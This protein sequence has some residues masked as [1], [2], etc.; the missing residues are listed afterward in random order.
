M[1]TGPKRAARTPVRAAKAAADATTPRTRGA[2]RASYADASDSDDDALVASDQRQ[3]RAGRDQQPKRR[4]AAADVVMVHASDTS[5]SDD[6]Q[7]PPA[8]R[9]Q[10]QQPA[11]SARPAVVSDSEAAGD[12]SDSEQQHTAM[13]GGGSEDEDSFAT[14][15]A[16]DSA[17]GGGAG[18]GPDSESGSESGDDVRPFHS[19]RASS[20]PRGKAPTAAAAPARTPRRQGAVA[21]PAVT[22]RRGAGGAAP[23]AA[24]TPRSARGAA[25]TPSGRLARSCT[26]PK[27]AQPPPSLATPLAKMSLATPPAARAPASAKLRAR[28]G[29]AAAAAVPRAGRRAGGVGGGAELPVGAALA[30]VDVDGEVIGPGDD[31][32][33]RL[34][35][36]EYEEDED[37]A[38]EVCH[39]S[40]CRRGNEILECSTCLRGFHLRCL[41]PPLKAVPDGD[42]LCPEC[43]AGQVPPPPARL[44]AK[45][46]KLLHGTN[47]LALVHVLGCQRGRAPDGQ[48]EDQLLVRYYL[49]PQE[50]HLGRTRQHGAREVFLGTKMYVEP[51]AALAGRAFVHAPAAFADAREEEGNDVFV[52]DYEYDETWRRFKR[53]NDSDSD[54]DGEPSGSGS[55]GES[56]DGAYRPELAPHLRGA[57]GGAKRKRHGQ[58]PAAM[59]AAAAAAER[60]AGLGAGDLGGARSEQADAFGRLHAALSLAAVPASLP[61]RDDERVRLQGFVARALKEDGG[62]L[63]ICGVPGTGKTALVMEVLN[64]QAGDAVAAGSQLV[65]INCLQLPSPQHVFSRLWE[66]LSGQHL[67][68]ARARD[69][70]QQHFGVG[71]G[72][73]GGPRRR[74]ST[75]IV[76][77]EIDMLLTRDQAVLYQLFDWPATPGSRL[78][79]IGIS[80]THDLDARVLPRIASR[81]DQAKLPFAPYGVQ[82]LLAIVRARLHASAAAG[83]VEEAAV[84]LACRKV[85]SETGDVRRA[86]ELLRRAVEIARQQHLLEHSVTQSGAGGG[87]GGGVQPRVAWAEGQA[88]LVRRA[89]VT[90][91]QQEM[92]SALHHKLLRSRSTWEKVLLVAVVVE[93]RATGRSAVIIQSVAERAANSIAALV[94]LTPPPLGVL[95]QCLVRLAGVRLL[96]SDGAHLKAAV[97]LNVD[98]EDVGLAL[99]DDERLSRLHTLL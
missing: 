22:P 14:A 86:L 66:K 56:D 26:Q 4:P 61:C 85:A 70:L 21:A 6:E 25:A 15:N 10:R 78:A 62:V 19:S 9:R 3:R 49:L 52:C 16:A 87:D 29:A 27:A 33:V 13:E 84:Q 94:G 99:R 43:N 72:A 59:L 39:S 37:E 30:V 8:G 2:S 80:N 5:D 47:Q 90:Q 98:K 32:Y 17:G 58:L 73:A 46:Q 23:A 97:A 89:H 44:I 40:K 48:E 51:V 7:A 24:A 1:D 31:A 64:A 63:Y 36:Y 12:G 82:A 79:V 76:L 35:E 11:A 88:P 55:G 45:W 60:F 41:A 74:Y 75:I 20:R 93:A 34:D 81:L 95:Q 28:G 67:G 50:T 83:A 53:R 57:R 69:A 38:C 42:W 77:D 91:A 68:P 71:G 18:G 65:A 54:A 92:F 96:L